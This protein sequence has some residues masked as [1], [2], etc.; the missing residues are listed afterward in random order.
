MMEVEGWL[1]YLDVRLAAIAAEVP[2]CHLAADIG[3]DHGKLS[4]WLLKAGRVRHMI[5]SDISKTSRDKARDL[6][7]EHDVS[8]RVTLSG[9]DGLFALQGK[10]Q[11][12]I[13]AGMGGGLVSGILRQGVDLHKATLIVSA[14]TELPLVRDA[15]ID[16]EYHISKE[17]LIRSGGRYYRVITAQPG[18]QTLIEAQRELGVN[19]IDTP[20]ASLIDYYRWQLEIAQSWRGER[21]ESYRKLVKEALDEQEANHG[22]NHSGLAE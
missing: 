21:G 11:A 22:S 13:I 9:E 2:H 14:H 17:Q 16:R 8:D 20:S 19:V 15:L 12:V 5:V 4:C 1:P 18:K 6:F 7:M 3:A 10:P